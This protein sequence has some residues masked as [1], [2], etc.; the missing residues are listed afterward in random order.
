MR[1]CTR[2]SLYWHL[3]VCSGDDSLSFQICLVS[4]TQQSFRVGLPLFLNNHGTNFLTREK[5]PNSAQTPPQFSQD[6]FL[7]CIPTCLVFKALIILSI[8]TACTWKEIKLELYIHITPRAKWYQ[9]RGKKRKQE[10]EP[11]GGVKK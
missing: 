6:G 10:R 5:L 11:Q 1:T 3:S 4:T 8:E 7:C 9:K 2:A